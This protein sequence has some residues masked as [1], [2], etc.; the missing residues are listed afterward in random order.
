MKHASQGAKI[1]EWVNEWMRKKER[2]KLKVIKEKK[3]ESLLWQ[4]DTKS[5]E[6]VGGCRGGGLKVEYKQKRAYKK[7]IYIHAYKFKRP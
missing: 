5:H 2:E 6:S 1:K 3:M 7:K 4:T